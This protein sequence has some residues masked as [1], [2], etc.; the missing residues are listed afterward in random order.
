M[1]NFS[2]ILFLMILAYLG[3]FCGSKT[4]IGETRVGTGKAIK[5]EIPLPAAREEA[6]K[7]EEIKEFVYDA[8]G[9]TDPFKP[10]IILQDQ[11]EQTIVGCA[12][13]FDRQQYKLTGIIM[14]E[15][16]WAIFEDPTG[17]GCFLKSG[18]F[19]G[20]KGDYVHKILNGRVI[21]KGKGVGFEGEKQISMWLYKPAE[22]GY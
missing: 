9:K 12:I 6:P 10:Y 11:A 14:G 16:S 8:Q 5:E 17:L 7:D 1:H 19:I 3:P 15:N 18:D 21:I 4:E 13:K 2:K 22:E 20:R